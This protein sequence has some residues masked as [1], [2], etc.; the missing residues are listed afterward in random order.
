MKLFS[1]KRRVA[2]VAAILFL[3]LFLLRPGASQLKS[4]IIASVSSGVGRSVDI[5]AVHLRLL[6]WP[7]F[8]LDNLV[9]YDDPAFGAEPML[10]ASEVSAALRLTSVLRGRLEIARLDL[11]EPSLNL[12][13]GDNGRWNVETLLE[14]AARTPL[15]PTGKAKSEPRPA[16]P[17]IQANSARINFK[18][19]PEKKPY[20]LTNADFSLWQDSENTWGVRL[21]AQPMRTD[22]NLN[23]TGVLRVNGTWQRAVALHDTPLQFNLEWDGPQLGQLTKFL[24]GNDQGWRGGVLMGAALTGTPAKLQITS[25]VSV[26]DFR[27]YDITTNQGLR[28]AA[29]CDGYYSTTDRGFHGVLC[30]APVET[31]L[32]TLQGDF[33]PAGGNYGLA[34]SADNVPAAALL[35]LARRIKKNLPE[36]LEATG[37]LRGNLTIEKNASKLHLDGHGEITDFQAASATE[38]AELGPA[39]LP[40]RLTDRNSG[41]T[42]AGK[43]QSSKNAGLKMPDGPHLEFGPWSAGNGLATARGWV[44]RAGYG[45]ALS[46]E[47]EIAKVLRAARTLGIP[48][49][50]TTASGT[51]LLDL[52][53]AGSWRGWSGG[54]PGFLGP[55]VTGTAKLRNVRVALHGA[56][57][58]LEVTSADMELLPSEVR[59]EKLTAK[60]AD[61]SWTGSLGMPRGCGT[62]EACEVRFHLSASQ[63]AL[64]E[65]IEWARPRLSARPWYRV[66]ESSAQTS[67]SFLAS[68]R[69]SGRITTERLIARNLLAER[70][71]AN[72]NLDHGKLKVSDLS[73]DL[74]GGKQRGTWHADFTVE[75]PAYNGSGT[76]S[77]ISLA[78]LAAEMKDPWIAGMAKGSYE[79]AA[80]GWLAADFWQ[81]AEGTLQFDAR[82]GTL[83][84]LSLAE[85][86]GPLRISGLSGL[87]RLHGGKLQLKDAK[88]DSPSGKFDLSGTYSLKRELDFK[89]ARTRAGTAG[90]AITG[91]LAEPHVAPLAGT[92]Q[93]RLKPESSPK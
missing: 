65:M 29:H 7:G 83:P 54:S 59:V 37:T 77:G 26:Q 14:R 81:S 73:A 5:G 16:F 89:L 87:A 2:A 1:S 15:A 12:V 21:K 76:L 38:K 80:T 11:T 31:G 55:Q 93:A 53:V 88:L 75:P 23:D 62:P 74:L 35:A 45:V 40:F 33:G 9:V 20:A 90:F 79:V 22:L 28:L 4:R 41:V 39:S 18:N 46:G 36:D 50:Q 91:T 67:P 70:V 72:V 42:S 17:Y 84:H 82:D 69:A 78:Q 58:P 60:A 27:R 10:R 47:T 19:G 63:I 34:L 56:G 43:N 85:D 92:E 86:E 6:P 57:G 61:A 24:T 49:L 64:G 51:A 32:I 66:L 30:R 48:A 25:D 3:L 52:Q 8:D 68:L 13:R 44:N 71:S